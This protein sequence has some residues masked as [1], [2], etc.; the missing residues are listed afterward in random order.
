MKR[1]DDVL[2][3]NGPMLYVRWD[4]SGK[5]WF[6]RLQKNSTKTELQTNC[7]Q[8]IVT[9]SNFMGRCIRKQKLH[10]QLPRKHVRRYRY[11]VPH[12]GTHDNYQARVVTNVGNIGFNFS[13]NSI[14]SLKL[15][16]V[17]NI[18]EKYPVSVFLLLRDNEMTE[19]SRTSSKE[20]LFFVALEHLAHFTSILQFCVCVSF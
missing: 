16:V 14:H 2:W 19:I 3:N 1:F 6:R 5:C 7:I 9:F 18:K 8:I 10:A 4:F 12:Q 11:M 17:V 20:E 13:L 15:T